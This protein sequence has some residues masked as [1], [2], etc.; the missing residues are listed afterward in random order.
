MAKARAEGTTPEYLIRQAISP[1]LLSVPDEA[2]A[3]AGRARQMTAA[4]A[5][6]AF[7]ELE[8]NF[9]L[10]PETG[11]VFVEWKKCTATDR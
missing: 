11:N 9:H 1:M 5:D 2:D 7:E 6:R 3:D 8:S 4:E 10:L